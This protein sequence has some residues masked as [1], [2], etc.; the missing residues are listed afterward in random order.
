MHC[1]GR[2][3]PKLEESLSVIR[4]QAESAVSERTWLALR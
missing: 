2:E 4:K 1:G 3:A